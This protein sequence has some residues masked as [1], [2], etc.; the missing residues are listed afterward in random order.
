MS[1]AVDRVLLDQ[2]YRARLVQLRDRAEAA[3]L[4]KNG[5]VEVLRARLI[6]HRILPKHDLS[7]DGIQSMAHQELGETLKVFG[8]KSTGSHKEL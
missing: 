1:M 4:P 3:G 7:W 6:Q 5:S 8:I 2:L